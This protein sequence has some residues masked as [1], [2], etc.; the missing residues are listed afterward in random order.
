MHRDIKCHSHAAEDILEGRAAVTGDA[1]TLGQKG[2]A[3]EVE[4]FSS[5]LCGLHLGVEDGVDEHVLL[6]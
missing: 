2:L 1:I 4:L 5:P 6:L 3:G